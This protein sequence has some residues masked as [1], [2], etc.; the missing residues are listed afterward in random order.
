M[1]IIIAILIVFITLILSISYYLGPNDLAKC[2]I[3]P[4]KTAPCQPADAIVAISGGDTNARA[5][6]AIQ[7]YQDGWASLLI[8]SGAAQ[9]KSGP[10]NAAVMR[11]AA[12]DAGI[13]SEN[14]ITEDE[15]ETTKQN[16]EK[17]QNI[18]IQHDVSSVIVVTS[19][20]HQLR[21]GLEFS[22]RADSTVDVR[23]RPVAADNQWSNLWW[24]TPVGWYLAIGE[25]IKTVIFYAGATR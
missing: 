16:A 13:A 25:L 14:I 22:K 2:E 24:L 20:Y 18:F 12:L 19:A 23:N 3:N 5:Q 6:E 21:A 4:G 10:S 8:F 11:Q 9:D 17:T 1:R 7:L 15:G